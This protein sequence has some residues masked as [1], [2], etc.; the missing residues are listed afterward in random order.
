MKFLIPITFLLT[1]NVIGAEMSS[2][3]NNR[4]FELRQNKLIRYYSTIDNKRPN[5]FRIAARLRLRQEIERC[6]KDFTALLEK[7]SGDMFYSLPM[8][9]AYLHGR[10][11]WTPEI[12]AKAR[13]VWKTYLPYRGDTENHWVMWHAALLLAAETWPDL[14]A[15]EWANGRTSQENFDDAA[16]FFDYWFK[17]TSTIGQGEFDS[18]DYIQVYLGSLFVLYDFLKNPILKQ[19]VEMALHWLLADYALDYLGGAYTGGHSRIY[20]REIINPLRDG[21]VAFGYLFFGNTPFPKDA[22]LGF[23]MLAALTNYRMPAIVQRIATD[24]SRPYVAR[25]RKR[26]RN[27]IRLG[28]ELNPPV[29]KYNYM[30]KNFSLGCLDGG[31]QQPIQIHTWSVTYLYDGDKVDNLFAL[32]PYYSDIEL[33]MFFP[34][35]L[36]VMVAEVVK[37]KGTYDKKDKWTGGSPYERTFQHQNSIIALYDLAENTPYKHI[38]YYFPKSLSKRESDDSGWIFAQGGSAYIAVRPFK[39]GDW[40]EEKFC[41]RLRSP[42]LRNGL[43]TEVADASEFAGWEAF[44]SKILKSSL[45]LS[46]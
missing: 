29:Y 21:G 26:V 22:P 23:P 46:Q 31:L 27:V 9:G 32:H 2:S 7:P 36:K 6:R 17:T 45:D 11:F 38:D 12:H 44:K 16:G 4:A 13:H 33:G 30:T 8:M 39:S 41:H 1:L 14:P 18:P 15:S 5:F 37:S 20:E 35:K 42:H 19:R 34:E 40:S 28:E 43:I 24:R 10:E 25:E 3:S